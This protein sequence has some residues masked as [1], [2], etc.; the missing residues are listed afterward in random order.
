MTR[1]NGNRIGHRAGLCLLVLGIALAPVIAGAETRISAAVGE[2]EVGQGEPP[3]WRAATV[4]EQLAARSRLRTSWNGRAE[5]VHRGS[6]IRLYG[7]SLLQLPDAEAK[8]TRSIRLES[9]A[10]LFDV[11][12]RED[13]TFEVRTPDVIVSVKGTRFAVELADAAPVEVAVYRGTVGVRSL[14]A[15]AAREVLVHEGFGAIGGGDGPAEIFLLDHDDPWST[16]GEEAL[17]R[18][19][20]VAPPASRAPDAPT[21]TVRNLATSR[22]LALAVERDPELAHRLAEARSDLRAVLKGERGAVGDLASNTVA[23]LDPVLDGATDDVERLLRSQFIE[24]VLGSTGSTVAVL[25]SPTGLLE[26]TDPALGTV[27]QLDQQTLVSILEG[28]S[29]LPSGLES[30]LNAPGS[31]QQVEVA[32]LL[33]GLLGR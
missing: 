29:S 28:T 23:P 4:G 32:T 2:V 3:T 9:G 30:L 22:A 13:G 16:W 8:D 26:I 31:Q 12:H 15:R 14:A 7:N 20:S 1:I 33:L 11:E 19:A 6:T 27:W 5:L 17:P 24:E 18:S 25:L 21:N 10:G